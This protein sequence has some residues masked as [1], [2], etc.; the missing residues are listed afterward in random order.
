MLVRMSGNRAQALG[1]APAYSSR[2]DKRHSTVTYLTV[3]DY[4]AV[5]WD[6]YRATV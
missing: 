2:G 6:A 5:G 4:I 3:Q 1:I